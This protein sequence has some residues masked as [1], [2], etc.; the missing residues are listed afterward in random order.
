MIILDFM[1][2]KVYG[3]SLVSNMGVRVQIAAGIQP[4]GTTDDSGSINSLTRMLYYRSGEYLR[5]WE[6]RS[7]HF[8]SNVASENHKKEIKP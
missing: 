4:S 5:T 7:S 2:T 8:L 1:L 3:A 6:I